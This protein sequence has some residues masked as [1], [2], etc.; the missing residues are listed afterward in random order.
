MQ[1][2]DVGTLTTLSQY[3]DGGY[4]VV[5]TDELDHLYFRVYVGQSTRL[6]NRIGDHIKHIR[7][8]DVSKLLYYICRR[9]SR[10]AHFLRFW[11]IQPAYKEPLQHTLLLNILEMVMCR[12]FESISPQILTQ[13]FGPGHYSNVGLNIVPPLLQN[14][15][16][17]VEARIAYTALVQESSDSEIRFWPTFRYP[18]REAQSL[19]S[20]ID[21]PQPSM[22]YQEF[23]S[24]VA[25]LCNQLE[26]DSTSFKDRQDDIQEHEFDIKTQVDRCEQTLNCPGI[27]IRPY[28]SLCNMI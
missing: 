10:T 23:H 20:D 11:S 4:L 12:V 27:L 3:Q 18:R 7:R 15:K 6:F 13:Y 16:L 1:H 5:V 24:A 9:P 2:A 8:G 19:I 26:L 28:G 22:N 14:M 21:T 17:T 25:K